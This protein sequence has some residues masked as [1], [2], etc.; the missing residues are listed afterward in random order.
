MKILELLRDFRERLFLLVGQRG[1]KVEPLLFLDFEH[2]AVR[3]IASGHFDFVGH[4]RS[5]RLLIIRTLAVSA[6]AL[7]LVPAYGASP[8]IESAANGGGGPGTSINMTYP[9]TITA[10]A[11]IGSCVVSSN[12]SN[13]FT[14]PMGWTKIGTEESGGSQT[15]GC[16]YTTAVGNE[17]GGTFAVGI[18]ESV[19]LAGRTWSITGAEVPG[20]QAPEAV[21]ASG[22]STSADPP[23]V[24]PTGGSKDYLWVIFTGIDG[25]RTCTDPA[26]YTTDGSV[27]NAAIS[28]CSAFRA[29]TASS[30][31]P[32]AFTLSTTETWSVITLAVHPTTAVAGPS[33]S[34]GPTVA[35]TT[36]GFTISGTITDA[37]G[38]VYAAALNPGTSAPADCDAVQALS[39]G[40]V[41]EITASEAWTADTPDSFTLTIA[42]AFPRYDVYVCADDGTNDPT[43]LTTATDQNRSPASGKEFVVTA[44]L[45]GTSPFSQP[46]DVAC[47]TDGSTGVLTGCA[48]LSDFQVGMLASVSDGFAT[49]GPFLVTAV[50]VSTITVDGTSDS[51]ETDVTITGNVTTSNTATFDPAIA[52]GDVWEVDSATDQGDT[53]TWA[54]DLDLVYT[55]TSGGLLTAIEFCPQDVSD[56]TGA[57]TRPCTDFASPDTLYVFNQ[58]PSW[59]DFGQVPI[60]WDE[61]EAISSIALDDSCEHTLGLT[62]TYA[63]RDGTIPTGVT[64]SSGTLSGTP[65]T[66]DES[67]VTVRFWCNAG[68]LFDSGSQQ[69]YVVNTV[70]M[71]TL[72]D[73]DLADAQTDYAS[74]F[75]WASAL[76]FEIATSESCSVEAA[77]EV[78]AQSPTA[79]AEAAYDAS[80]S[81][82]LSSGEA[83]DMTPPVCTAAL[84]FVFD[85]DTDSG[86]TSLVGECVSDEQPTFAVTDGTLPNGLSLSGAGVITGT[87]DTE[88]ES[89]ASVEITATE[90]SSTLTDTIDTT[91][92]VVNTVTLPDY[93][94][95]NVDTAETAHIAAFPWQDEIGFVRF[96]RAAMCDPETTLGDVISQDPAASEEVGAFEN[97]TITYSGVC[98]RGRPGVRLPGLQIPGL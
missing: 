77:G 52:A 37:N 11:L 23:E 88:D 42:S 57:Y 70:T 67:G 20:T 40:T 96:F 86:S 75:P 71:P 48:D 85:E 89:G 17:D 21:D 65:T 97:V 19:G 14:W 76:G 31:D 91:M 41:N 15:I 30:E 27:A 73:S 24:T 56:G 6:C 38:T 32:G 16:A 69:F 35:A 78:T 90:A 68:G 81:V 51:A 84:V 80:V 36:N 2:H 87:P 82:T 95:S 74:S 33:F 43:A 10:D 45:S 8:V 26:N 18:N 46:T 92:Y 25:N 7:C 62:K 66:E 5:L 98:A 13:T 94:G 55:D 44:S 4:C 53:I 9:A 47:D 34:S 3:R 22:S 59:E 12:A 39:G 54:T 58:A 93:V 61:D 83:C 79:A 63:V 28:F 60:V 1:E 50:G 64:L 72:T 29:L 49:T